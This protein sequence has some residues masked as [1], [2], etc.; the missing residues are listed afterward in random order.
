MATC[1]ASFP[2]VE[3]R[4]S[5][6]FLKS[7]SELR[8][9]CASVAQSIGRSSW[10]TTMRL[11]SIVPVRSIV[12]GVFLATTFLMI[13][14]FGRQVQPAA[15]GGFSPLPPVGAILAYCAD[16]DPPPGWTDCDGK[17]IDA[18]HGFSRD[19]VAEAWWNRT[20]PTL[21]GRFLRGKTGDES[22]GQSYGS[23]QVPSH[24]TTSGGAHAHTLPS[25][26]GGIALSKDGWVNPGAFLL[27]DMFG[28]AHE[29]GTQFLQ[30]END[31]GRNEH[32]RGKGQHRHLL[33]GNTSEAGAHQHSIEAVQYVPKYVAIRYIIRIM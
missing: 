1:T 14:G 27:V 30:T 23:D 7:I 5:S 12:H 31:N 4:S 15:Q 19:K 13:T 10:G 25:F 29:N 26:T 11:T 18:A 32:Q 6:A 28:G 9:F 20:V 33:G 22:I 21:N 3:V 16:G 8:V 24:A 2:M 17:V